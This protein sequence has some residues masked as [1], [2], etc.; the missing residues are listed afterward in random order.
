MA[1]ESFTAVRVAGGL[2]PSE[3]LSR[4]A[5]GVLP[6]QSSAD[7]HLAAGE[8]FRE[9]A[10]RAW[11][12]LTGVWASYRQAASRLPEG[13]RGTSLTRERWLLVLL[14]ELDYGRVPA[15]SAGGIQAGAK[16]FPISHLWGQVPIHLLG[17]TVDLDRRSHGVAGAATSS[18]QSM[19]QELLNVSDAHL[20]ALLSN[21]LTLRL[22][23]DSTSLVGSAYVEFDLEAIFDGEIFADF[24]LLYALCHQSRLEVRDPEKGPASCWLETWRTESLESGTRA[25][26]QLRDGV[27]SAINT[28]GTGLLTHPANSRLRDRLAAGSLRE[29]DINHGLLRLVYRLLFSFVAEDRELL[30]DPHASAAARQRYQNFFSTQRLRRVARRRRGTRHTDQWQALSVVW[31]G[32]GSVNGRPELGLVGIGG[33]FE[34]TSFDIFR[35][36][37]L[38]NEAL[39]KAVRHLSLVEEAGSKIKRVVDYRNLGAEELG[40]IYETLLEY[41]PSWDAGARTFSLLSAAGN[42]RKSTGSYYTPTSLIDCLLDSALDPVIDRAAQGSDPEKALLD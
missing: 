26:N 27:I 15:T 14:R 31:D 33:L 25:L 21:G 6:G 41:V 4:I 11:A 23:R 39:L 1:T 36:C 29:S 5:A 2:M 24:L 7:Y 28:L 8:T 19:V 20:W 3:L 16:A 30:L 37:E 38:S 34:P 17:N 42:D 9:A 40:S 12:Y 35:D 32:L 18:P 22:L 10:N 13:D